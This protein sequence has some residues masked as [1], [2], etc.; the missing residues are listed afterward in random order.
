MIFFSF[1]IFFKRKIS[2]NFYLEPISKE[3]FI[4]SNN[5]FMM[6]YLATVF[7]GT[8]YPIFTDALSQNKISVGPPF[9]NAIIFPVVVI[10]LI[11]MEYYLMFLLL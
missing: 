9:Y 7:I 6:F 4:L 5:W 3:T 2:D 11:F 10:F 1:V 8:I